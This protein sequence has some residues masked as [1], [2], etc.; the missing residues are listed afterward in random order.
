MNFSPLHLAPHASLDGLPDNVLLLILGYLNLVALVL[1]SRV[2]R[3][4]HHLSKDMAAWETVALTRESMGKKL[5][6]L[7]LK[8][9]IRS[10]L[11]ASLRGIV[12]EETTL[13]G[14]AVITAAL[15]DLLFNCCPK[16][17]SITLINC[18]M[19]KVCEDYS[20]RK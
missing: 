14:N 11:P 7:T 12:L 17:E 16:I 19:R 4:F 6:S 3:R 9:V 2:C 18:D 1:M 15:M 8:R 10:H 20:K 5:N 13:R